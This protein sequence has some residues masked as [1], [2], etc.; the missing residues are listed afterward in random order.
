MIRL[1]VI[2]ALLAALC[3]APTAVGSGGRDAS[4]ASTRYH[5]CGYTTSPYGRLGI[6]VLK[7]S[8]ACLEGE[9][10]I[11]RAFYVAGEPTHYGDSE[12]YPG[13]WICGG[14]MGYY[15]CSRP[16]PAHPNAQVEGRACDMPGVGCPAN[17]RY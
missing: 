10:L 7:G 9:R 4:A 1:S 2:G 6:Y 3:A 12:R 16:T 14:Q 17:T 5:R 8:V 11:H 15:T 13:S